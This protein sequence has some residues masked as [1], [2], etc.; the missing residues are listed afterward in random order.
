MKTQTG[1][2]LYSHRSGFDSLRLLSISSECEEIESCVLFKIRLLA[3]AASRASGCRGDRLIKAV[4]SYEVAEP[5]PRRWSNWW[6][7]K[8]LKVLDIIHKDACR[9]IQLM[10]LH[11]EL[12]ELLPCISFRVLD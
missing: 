8:T 9:L 7:K 3:V 5:E 12:V 10:N 4:R 6:E 11:L 2:I 1:Y